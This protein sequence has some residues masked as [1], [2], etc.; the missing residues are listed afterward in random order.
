MYVSMILKGSITITPSWNCLYFDGH[1]PG[2]RIIG[3]NSAQQASKAKKEKGN[4]SG[5]VGVQTHKVSA[6]ELEMRAALGLGSSL[7]AGGGDSIGLGG[8]S[9]W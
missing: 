9:A 3:S 7:T 1:S 8:S 2:A 4:L 6:A 5:V